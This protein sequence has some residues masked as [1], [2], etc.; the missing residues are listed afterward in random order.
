[1]GDPDADRRRTL[2]RCSGLDRLGTDPRVARRRP[3]ELPGR[4]RSHGSTGRP[5]PTGA[6]GRLPDLDTGFAL[7]EGGAA[8]LLAVLAPRRRPHVRRTG[9]RLLARARRPVEP[10]FLTEATALHTSGSDRILG[11]P[12]PK[13]YAYFLGQPENDMGRPTAFGM[14]GS[15]GSIAFADR[16]HGFAFAYT[17]NR[18]VGRSRGTH[19]SPRQ[20][21]PLRPRS[22][23]V[24]GP[25]PREVSY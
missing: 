25:P 21:G 20:R 11:H 12:V 3:S 17:Q 1:V 22:R 14:T 5:S 24:L 7:S 13:G 16:E 9:G 4:L 18:L 10:T 2:H 6:A 23:R 8:R 15:G 19:G